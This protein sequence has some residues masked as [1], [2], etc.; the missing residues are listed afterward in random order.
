[1]VEAV[2]GVRDN[3]PQVQVANPSAPAGNHVVLDL[4]SDYRADGRRIA[5]GTPVQGQ[6]LTPG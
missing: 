5:R 1:V 3:R 2:D 4:G 6:F